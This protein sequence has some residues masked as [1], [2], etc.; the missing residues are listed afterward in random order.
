MAGITQQVP[1]Y[2]FG[3]SEQ[4][5]ELKVPGQVSNLI[6][7][8]P[9]V[10]RGLQKRPGSQY[11]NTLYANADAKWFHIYRDEVEQYI[12][13]VT[14]TGGVRVWNAKTGSQ[15]NVSGNESAYLSFTD[16][17]D[18]QVL[19]I[20]DYTFI[21]NRKKTV[22]MSSKKSPAKVNQAFISLKQ[23]KPGTQYALDVSTP[24]SGISHSY[25]RATNV[26][27][28]STG[29][30]RYNG[31]EGDCRFA[32]RQL[33]EI[34][35]V[36]ESKRNLW[37]EIDSRC[38]AYQASET[39]FN[40]S[41]TISTTLK[42]GGE[43]IVAGDLFTVSMP[44]AVG[45]LYTIVIM[46]S[47]YAYAKANLAFV[48]PTPTPFEGLGGSADS[49]LAGIT[50]PLQA[51]GFTVKTIG[52]G[53]YITH[54]NPFVVTA[55]DDTLMSII[56]N[57]GEDVSDLP[58]SCKDGYIVKVANS[59]DEEDDY[60][61]KFIGDNG[62]G[63]GVWEECVAPDISVE[64][65]DSTMPVQLVRVGGVS[66]NL[67]KTEWEERLVGDNNTNQKPTF[68]GKKINKMVFFR[69]R[70][71]ILAD[72][73]IILS[74]PGDFFN[75]WNKTAT[76]VVPIDPIDLSCSSQ[77]P[78]ILYDSLE[79]NA[80][81]VLFA[82]N[83]QFLMTTDS[84]IFSPKT[85]KIN[86]LSSYN[87][88]TRTRPVSLGT[89]IGFL[90]NGGNYTR[91]F[92]MANVNRNAEPTVIEQSKLVSKLIPLDYEL[93]AESKENNFLALAKKT[94]K[95]IWVYKYFNTGEKRIQSAW[96]NW[97]LT[98]N[99]LYHCLMNDIYYAVVKFDNGDINLQSIDI[100]PTDGE[101]FFSERIYMDNMDDVPSSA[102]T[103]DINTLT[104]SFS[105]PSGF[106][107][108]TDLSVFTLED[109]NNQGRFEEVTVE[110]NTITIA[111]DW[112]D[113]GLTLGYLYG[114]LVRFPTIYPQTKAGDSVRSDVRSSLTIHR[115]KLNLEAAG[116][117]ESTLSRKGKP[118]YVQLYECR[119]QDGYKANAVAFTRSKDQT[120][121][122]YERNT[123]VS[124][125]LTSSHPSPCTLISMNW[126]GDYNPRYYKSV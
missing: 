24:G 30:D 98:G 83:Q 74:R 104:T 2:I 121:P 64:F 41:Y 80:G 118:D 94:S 35:R 13:Q 9:D 117:Y 73:N 79:L 42:F 23:I 18:I 81:L 61:V 38:V 1:N 47:E 119:E 67:E 124:L 125:T 85:A 39:Q 122:V 75:F 87:F 99:V 43:Y 89:T 4:P 28:S 92:E 49:I 88:N 3:I 5:D 36:S 62:D 37:V 8:L 93:I 60:Y 54:S 57:S 111:G 56:Q 109:G 90:N 6:N 29:F 19:S 76:A 12:G 63:P 71:G 66:F 20:N 116:V 14:K 25:Q 72:E 53:I 40:D 10:T 50:T 113:T 59:G 123:N 107:S 52:S 26:E 68:V 45:S 32:G 84:D 16:S 58:S 46:S 70:L 31:G 95:H 21:S 120:I 115:V 82:E 112:T 34:D 27:I 101:L 7:G 48:R 108:N 55:P 103:Y 96:V 78:S 65:N 11:V 33:F 77:S 86:A 114:M 69:N 106:P 15:L 126:E 51:A 102:L 105:K 100:R 97:T 22:S 110:S 17:E 91:M 44:S